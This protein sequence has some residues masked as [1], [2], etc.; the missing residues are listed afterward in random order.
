MVS[1]WL[2]ESV[3]NFSKYISN[4]FHGKVTPKVKQIAWQ[5]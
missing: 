1:G 4:K 5:L 3:V 2:Q